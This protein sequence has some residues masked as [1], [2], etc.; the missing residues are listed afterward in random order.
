MLRR[1][2]PRLFVLGYYSI[3]SYLLHPQNLAEVSPS[4]FDEAEYR[5]L[6]R[7]RMAAV[8]DRLLMTLERSRNSYEILKALPKETKGRAMQEIAEATASDDF[9]TLYPFLYMKN[10]RPGDYLAPLHLQRLEL[11]RTDWMRRAIA[12]ALGVA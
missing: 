2:Q 5:R 1:E 4:G 12:D 9:E 6:I 3:E 11:A 7:E 10:Q 8:R